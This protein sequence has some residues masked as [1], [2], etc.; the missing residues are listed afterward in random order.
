M[1]NTLELLKA[2]LAASK[3][4]NATTTPIAPIAAGKIQAATSAHIAQAPSAVENSLLVVSEHM[5]Q[6]EGF[7]PV[8]FVTKLAAVRQGVEARAPGIENYF[9]ELNRNLNQ[10]PELCHLL[11]DDQLAALTA[12]LFYLTDTNMAAAVVTGKSKK[13]LTIDELQAM[14]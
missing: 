11:N 7:D 6:I 13:N 10:Y 8:A 4:A 9:R 3:A 12:G 14:F 5:R 1:A 2:K